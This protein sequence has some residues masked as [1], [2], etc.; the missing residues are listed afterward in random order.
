L[1]GDMANEIVCFGD[2]L[3]IGVLD[4]VVDHL[5]E[6]S[7]AI[8]PDVRD[9]GFAFGD[10]RDRRQDRPER[11]VGLRR[12]S[13]HDRRSVERAF[14]TA[15]DPGADEVEPAL[16]ERFLPPDRIGEERVAAIDD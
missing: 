6:M 1:A 13:W 10:R 15:G 11:R 7:G 14:F 8:G 3:H 9:A 2:E 5:Y 12:S 4:A 16:A